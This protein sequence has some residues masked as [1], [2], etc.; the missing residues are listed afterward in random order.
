[1]IIYHTILPRMAK[2]KQ[3]K[4]TTPAQVV[5]GRLVQIL[6]RRRITSSQMV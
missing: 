6:R 4:K 5:L 1:M 3:K 2:T